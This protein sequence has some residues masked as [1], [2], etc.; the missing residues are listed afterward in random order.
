M[1]ELQVQRADLAGATPTD[2]D[3]E[4]WAQAVLGERDG[5]RELAIRIVGEAEARALNRRFRDRDYATN[6]LSFPAAIDTA[7]ATAL[8]EAGYLQPLGDLVLCGPVV[9][10][11]AVTQGKATEDHWAHLVVHGI[12][13]LLGF[14]HQDAQQARDMEAEEIR[15]LA[16]LGIG[17]PYLEG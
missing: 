2:S 17:D 15:I 16:T 13:H 1:L 6:V 9:I 14:D 7:L 5:G 8:A 4:R 12:L 11:E 3:F 10:A